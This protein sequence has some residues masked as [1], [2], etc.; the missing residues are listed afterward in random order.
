[1][2]D[3]EMIKACTSIHVLR[4]RMGDREKHT[5]VVA[6]FQDTLLPVSMTKMSDAFQGDLVRGEVNS[7]GKV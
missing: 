3:T 6:D 2:L 5:M 7:I 1:M 4:E